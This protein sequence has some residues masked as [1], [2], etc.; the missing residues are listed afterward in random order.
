MDSTQEVNQNAGE[1]TENPEAPPKEQ[2]ETQGSDGGS[3]NKVIGSAA[4]RPVFL[5]NLR[6]EYSSD[7]I[8]E[9]FSRPL[10]PPGATDGTYQPIAIDRIDVK[11]GFCFVFL[12]DAS[13]QEEKDQVEKFVAA[14]NGM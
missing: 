14:I 10:T 6:P 5:G 12:K 7:K 8:H 3:N 2:G 13:S 9:L 4:I 1:Q 11:R